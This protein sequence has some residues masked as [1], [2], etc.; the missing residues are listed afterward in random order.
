[1]LATPDHIRRRRAWRDRRRFGTAGPEATP[2][3]ERASVRRDGTT[4]IQEHASTDDGDRM[5]SAP[6]TEST[7]TLADRHAAR[8]E[9]AS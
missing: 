9:F 7:E 3:W 4:P 5:F 1:M 6:L 2:V 8:A